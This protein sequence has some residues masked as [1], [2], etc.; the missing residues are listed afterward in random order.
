MVWIGTAFLYLFFF[1]YKQ[2]NNGT[3]CNIVMLYS[4]GKVFAH[5]TEESKAF[6]RGDREPVF[7]LKK[8]KFEET[9]QVKTY[10]RGCDN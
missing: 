5:F 10:T 1:K 3:M 2:I 8:R 6:L 4:H 7:R 9:F